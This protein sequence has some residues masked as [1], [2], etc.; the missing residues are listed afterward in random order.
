[1]SNTYNMSM[2]NTCIVKKKTKNKQTYQY[3][4][5][6]IPTHEMLSRES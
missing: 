2:S 3:K 5:I 4:I 6:G 1:M